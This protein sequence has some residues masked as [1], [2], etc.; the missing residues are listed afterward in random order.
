MKAIKIN[1]ILVA[2]VLLSG[3]LEAVWAQDIH[4]QDCNELMQDAEVA[5]KARDYRDAINFYIAIRGYCPELATSA[6]SAMIKVFTAIE[7][8]RN[9]ADRDRALAEARRDSLT[10]ALND[11]KARK[12]E[13]KREKERSDLMGKERKMA[14]EEKLMVLE[15][16]LVLVA[17]FFFDDSLALAYRN[18]KFG[19]V[20]E[21]GIPRIPYQYDNAENFMQI[22]LAR[23]SRCGIPLLV[24]RNGKEYCRHSAEIFDTPKFGFDLKV[25]MNFGVPDTAMFYEPSQRAKNM[26]MGRI[27]FQ[28]VILK[29]ALFAGLLTPNYMRRQTQALDLSGGNVGYLNKRIFELDSLQILLLQDYNLAQIDVKLT[30]L[31]EL[32]YLDLS[33][34]KLTGLPSEFAQMQQ[35]IALDLSGNPDLTQFPIELIDLPNLGWL[36]LRGTKIMDRHNVL[37]V[38]KLVLPDCQVI[39]D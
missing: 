31:K 10:L 19:F 8:L 30:R 26:K 27:R 35:L 6:D 13:M 17:A 37:R 21:Q 34:N 14:L 20:T 38:M 16:K 3:C 2:I 11:L 39:F 25:S 12:E 22:G 36:D 9:K 4:E 24:D 23:V 5:Y 32:R 7:R 28:K 1:C 33:D 18:Q 29:S 15:Q